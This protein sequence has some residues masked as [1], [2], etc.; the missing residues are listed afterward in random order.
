MKSGEE[1]LVSSRWFLQVFGL[2][3]RLKGARRSRG[4]GFV[5]CTRVWIWEYGFSTGHKRLLCM[6]I[7]KRKHHS[8]LPSCSLL[9][10]V[11]RTLPSHDHDGSFHTHRVRGVQGE[12]GGEEGMDYMT[13]YIDVSCALPSHE[14]VLTRPSFILQDQY[15]IRSLLPSL[16]RHQRPA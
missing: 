4:H 10:L 5:G 7:M 15:P 9:P 6:I 12:L 3:R 2:C 1:L 13:G 11:P 14:H 8:T 16:L